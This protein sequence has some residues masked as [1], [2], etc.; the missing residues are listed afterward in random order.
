[1]N[2]LVHSYASSKASSSSAVVEIDTPE[3]IPFVEGLTPLCF[4][5]FPT[6]LLEL[7]NM[8]L[9]QRCL[10]QEGALKERDLQGL[11]LTR[12]LKAAHRVIAAQKAAIGQMSHGTTSGTTATSVAG[13][14]TSD[15]QTGKD[16]D[17]ADEHA[18]SAPASLTSSSSRP[19]L[20]HHADSFSSV[21]PGPLRG[22]SLEEDYSEEDDYDINDGSRTGAGVDAGGVEGGGVEEVNEQGGKGTD[23]ANLRKLLLRLGSRHPP[24]LDPSTLSVNASSSTMMNM[25]M[26]ATAEHSYSPALS[27]DSP[28]SDGSFLPVELDALNGGTSSGNG[29]GNAY[30]NDYGSSS[31]SSDNGRVDHHNSSSSEFGSSQHK[32]FSTPPTAFGPMSRAGGTAG[33]QPPATAGGLRAMTNI[34]AAQLEEYSA[35]GGGG[36]GSGQVLSAGAGNGGDYDYD[37]AASGEGEDDRDDG[38][39]GDGNERQQP[40]AGSQVKQPT[41]PSQVSSMPWSLQSDLDHESLA[42]AAGT[43]DDGGADGG[44]ISANDGSSDGASPPF[45]DHHNSLLNQ[46]HHWGS[47]SPSS[48]SS[49][50]AMTTASTGGSAINA[51]A[52]SAT[53]ATATAAPVDTERQVKEEAKAPPSAKDG[54]QAALAQAAAIAASERESELARSGAE[55]MAFSSAPQA[56]STDQSYSSGNDDLSSTLA[57]EASGEDVGANSV[58]SAP[59]EEAEATVPSGSS[60]GRGREPSID[61]DLLRGSSD[62]FGVSERSDII[63]YYLVCCRS[64]F[65]LRTVRARPHLFPYLFHEQHHFLNDL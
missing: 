54:I 23:A 57:S 9:E 14:S 2:T 3:W 21:R 41:D 8:E 25:G 24:H 17:V 15:S 48:L 32:A 37:R 49:D 33:A 53:N 4:C 31:S 38:R 35:A 63:F 34:V 45:K 1:M 36:N 42:A 43:V 28:P 56:T 12:Q 13:A 16:G 5:L 50:P 18:A 29:H 44:A 6:G 40:S 65:L 52:A 39:N 20:R 10:V 60:G 19:P 27:L 22:D 30:N 55:A 51:A 11:R 7:Q 59:T 61:V 26:G 64:F 58:H 47:N 62:D 46:V